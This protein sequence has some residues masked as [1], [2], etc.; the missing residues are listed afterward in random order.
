MAEIVKIWKENNVDRVEFEFSCG[1]DSMNDTSIHIY[2][3]ENNLVSSTEL[4]DYFEDEVYRNVNFYEASDGHYI[5]ES[6]T[7]YIEFDDDMF[8]Y[9]KSSQSEWCESHPSTI[10]IELTEEER[11]LILNHVEDI[12]GG[13]DETCN[14][15]F[16]NDFV[17][18]DRMRELLSSIEEKV[19]DVT[20]G[21][22]PDDLSEEITDWYR[23]ESS[24]DIINSSGNLEIEINNEY[25][26]YREE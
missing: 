13:Y 10:E 1:G 4:V 24:D 3:K 26:T 2:D 8:I 18:T 23:F 14:I 16:K 6:G 15:N 12:N 21:F 5:G 9:N 22:E 19:D 7:V 25:Y 17:I 20:A 11:N